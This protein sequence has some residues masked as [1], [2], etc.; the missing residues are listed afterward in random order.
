M[1]KGKYLYGCLAA[2]LLL[3]IPLIAEAR[4]S[5]NGVSLNGADL[6]TNQ[7]IPADTQGIVRVEGGQLVIQKAPIAQ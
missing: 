7:I 4:L 1:L 6:N 2:G 5:S 3:S